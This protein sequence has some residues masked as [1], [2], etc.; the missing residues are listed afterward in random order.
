MRRLCRVL[1][2]ILLVGMV[3]PATAAVGWAA[4]PIDSRFPA[5]WGQWIFHSKGNYGLVLENGDTLGAAT[6]V[7]LHG[8]NGGSNQIWVQETASEGGAFLHPGYDRWLCMGRTRTGSGTP[9]VVQNCNGTVDQRWNVPKFERYSE[10]IK[11]ADNANACVDVPNSNFSQGVDLQ[12]WSCNDT[13]AQIWP[14]ALCATTSCQGYFPGDKGCTTAGARTADEFTLENQ[15]RVELVY[16]PGCQS[17]W[18]RMYYHGGAA[19]PRQVAI[20]HGTA[21]CPTSNDGLPYYYAEVNS[22]SVGSTRMFATSG[23]V[24]A[25][26]NNVLWGE[27]LR[28]TNWFTNPLG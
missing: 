21:C 5:N 7:Q 13:S 1:V 28:C 24:R 19:S 12:L 10:R 27:P 17:T 15:A 14:V 3:V 22:G 2:A 18:G 20:F 11:P 6:V 8:Q 4:P 23:V 16:A 26:Y 9:V 25:C